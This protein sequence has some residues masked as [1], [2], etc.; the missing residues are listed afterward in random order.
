MD[1]LS[2]TEVTVPFALMVCWGCGSET[3]V[4]FKRFGGRETYTGHG[5][6]SMILELECYCEDIPGR[7]GETLKTKRGRPV[8]GDLFLKTS[9]I[10]LTP[11]GSAALWF[12]QTRDGR[13]AHRQ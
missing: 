5:V 12:P 2:T 9:E 10:Q 11:R 13:S 6:L 4:S 7:A 1:V 8:G 3:G